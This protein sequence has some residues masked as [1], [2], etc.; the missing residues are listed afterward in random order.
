MARLTQA[1]MTAFMKTP[2]HSA[3]KPR[4]KAAGRPE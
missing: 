1:M 3:R 4:R 2:I